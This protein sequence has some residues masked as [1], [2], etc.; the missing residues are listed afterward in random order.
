MSELVVDAEGGHVLHACMKLQEAL[1]PACRRVFLWKPRQ[2]R[3]LTGR[4]VE[5]QLGKTVG[6]DRRMRSVH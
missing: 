4:E 6:G 1:L 3:A 2:V 5:A